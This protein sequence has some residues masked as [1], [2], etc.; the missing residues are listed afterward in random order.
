[1]VHGFH[2]A[3]VVLAALAV[4]GAV[5]AGLFIEGRGVGPAREVEAEKAGVPA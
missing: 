5:V 4:T 1:M 3:F 2:I